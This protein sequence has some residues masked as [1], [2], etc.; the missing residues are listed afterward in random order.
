VSPTSAASCSNLIRTYTAPTG[1]VHALR[2][3]DASF[4]PGQLTALVGPSGSGKSTLLRV[5]SLADRPTAGEVVLNGTAVSTASE[6]DLRTI[7]RAHI[8][9]VHQRPVHN[10]HPHLSV[11]EHLE[12]AARRRGWRGRSMRAL[13]DDTIEVVGL[14]HR[15]RSRPAQLSGGE[16]QRV[17]VA[18]A[19]VGS[20]SIVF[21]DEPTA[22]LDAD[23]GA[24]VA[25]LLR[26]AADQGTA[27]IM[28]THDHRL[29]AHADRVLAMHHGTLTSET[30]EAT[31]AL[32]VIDEVGR[33]QLP[34]ELLALFAGR[35][36]SLE[37]VDGAVVLR[38]QTPPEGMS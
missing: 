26:R 33:V 16:Q 3:I 11:A 10:L 31:G 23:S 18:A 17:S 25:H 20:P 7:R 2:S 37:M 14:T 29:A 36:A 9:V 27:V 38:P 6:G 15:R 8:G 35:R 30:H 24:A 19:S 22:E 12:E 21:A 4:P 28:S 1:E 13:V 5:L 34:P 32:A